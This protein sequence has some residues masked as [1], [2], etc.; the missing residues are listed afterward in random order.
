MITDPVGVPLAVHITAANV[1]DSRPAMI[2]VDKV[3]SLPSPSGRYRRP[4]RVLLGDKAYGT[5]ANQNGCRRR[6]VV[7]LLDRP[8][9]ITRP[10]L[11]RIRYVVER[12]LAGMGHCRR[13]KLCY[14]RRGEHFQAFHDLTAILL[15][16]K[17]LFH[18]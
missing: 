9:G 6:G 4:I 5:P 11:G 17:R 14:E 12:S 18:A 10:G 8:G 2:L 7:S 16:A 13:I 15:C 1:H 3:P